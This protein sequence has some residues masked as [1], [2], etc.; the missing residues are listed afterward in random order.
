MNLCW[1]TVNELPRA[2]SLASWRRG[3]TGPTLHASTS[4]CYWTTLHDVNVFSRFIAQGGT[5]WHAQKL[6]LILYEH[7]CNYKHCESCINNLNDR[8][9]TVRKFMLTESASCLSVWLLACTVTGTYTKPVTGSP[10][11]CEH[12]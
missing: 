11:K 3:T 9:P 1:L 5:T 12:P 6:S 2:I 8:L 7:K 4:G 10:V